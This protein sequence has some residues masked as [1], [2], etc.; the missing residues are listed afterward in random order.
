MQL[1]YVNNPMYALCLLAAV[2]VRQH[3]QNGG[4]QPLTKG[5]SLQRPTSVFMK[6]NKASLKSVNDI[7]EAVS[8]IK[9][10]SCK[11]PKIEEANALVLCVQNFGKKSQRIID[12]QSPI[13]FSGKGRIPGFLFPVQRT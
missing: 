1:H 3:V 2:C 11:Y 9:S 10:K 13:F 12:L 6:P 8:E 5:V 4:V 7:E